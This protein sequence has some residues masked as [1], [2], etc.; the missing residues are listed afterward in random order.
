MIFK[1]KLNSLTKVDTKKESKESDYKIT[2]KE[3]FNP[4]LDIRGKYSYEIEELLE[5]FIYEGQINS[6]NELTV[7]HGKGSGSLRKAVHDIIRKNKL[8]KS[9][10]LGN[11]NEGDTGVTI[12]E[13]KN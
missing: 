4:R 1:T 2:L 10:R 8:V 3:S 13:I 6:M 5:N 12:I 9:F 11:W 7:V